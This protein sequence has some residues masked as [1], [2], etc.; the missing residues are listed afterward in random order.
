MDATKINFCNLSGFIIQ[1]NR[2]KSDILQRILK[3]YNIDPIN[4]SEKSYNDNLINVMKHHDMLSCF[5]SKTSKQGR[6][7]SIKISLKYLYS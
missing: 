6:T 1:N 5:Q 2:L 7:C 4:L 3:K